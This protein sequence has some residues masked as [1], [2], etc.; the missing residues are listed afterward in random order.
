MFRRRLILG[1]LLAVLLAL[2][3]PALGMSESAVRSSLNA[4]MRQAGGAS[5]AY[6]LAL[7][8]DRPIYSLRPDRALIPASVNKL[9]VTATALRRYGGDATLD[10][11]VLAGGP[12]DE[13]GV[14]DGDLYLRGGGDPTLTSVRIAA[15]AAKLDLTRVRGRVLGDESHFDALRG[16]AATAGRLDWEIGGQLGALV[17]SRGYAGRGWQRRPAAV[18]ADALR[19]ALVKRGVK[20]TG[21]AGVGTAPDDAEELATTSSVPMSRLVQL[22]NV[23]SDNYYAETLLKG[24]GATFGDAG[25]TRDGAEVVEAELADLDVRPTIVDGSGLSRGDRASVRQVVT[26]LASMS[27]GDDASAFLGSLAVVGRSGTLRNR[28]RA[29]AA[30]DRCRG[31]TGT[32]SNVSNLAGIC[33]TADGRQVAFAIL[34]NSISPSRAHTLQDRMTAAIAR[35]D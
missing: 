31:K 5:A 6:V 2:P 10:T 4:Q 32:L 17:M 9:F 30:R 21:K 1:P 29:T 22:I 27:G 34:M 18:A 20:V 24:L 13:A 26:L 25:T 16:S 12:V 7:D 15:L 14:L 19:S 23:P 8:G 28:M 3:A 33:T 11:T 35:L